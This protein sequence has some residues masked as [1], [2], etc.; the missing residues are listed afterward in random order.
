MADH[1]PDSFGNQ[2]GG[3]TNLRRRSDARRHRLAAKPQTTF[4]IDDQTTLT[5]SGLPR[6][7]RPLPHHLSHA[8]KLFL[9]VVV[10][11]MTALGTPSLRAADPDPIEVLQNAHAELEQ[12]QA[13]L[14]TRFAQATDEEWRD[15]LRDWQ[16][17][18]AARREAIEALARELAPAPAAEDQTIVVEIPAKAS[19]A[20]RKLITEGAALE[21][22]MEEVASPHSDAEHRRDAIH[23]WRERNAAR[24]AA[25]EKLGREV[26][27]QRPASPAV[28]TL[29]PVAIPANASPRL[30]AYLQKESALAA[31][32]QAIRA[33]FAAANA[34]VQRDQWHTFHERTAARRQAQSREARALF[35]E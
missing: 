2:F 35:P 8:M 5:A 33:R 6:I 1:V 20:E 13:E 7:A 34:E 31:E 22:E 3:F 21:N 28:Q 23:A 32:E 12:E 17:H 24:I 15:A 30:R 25:H 29:P 27:A 19:A 18:T 9:S 4:P 11:G 16:E 10:L 14:A 26:Q